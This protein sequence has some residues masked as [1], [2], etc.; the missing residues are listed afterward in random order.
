MADGGAVGVGRLAGRGLCLIVAR[1]PRLPL[2]GRT[3]LVTGAGSGIGAATSR[4]LAAAGAGVAL[5]DLVAPDDLAAGLGPRALALAADVTDRDAISAAVDATV[6]RFGSLD[7]CFANAGIAA[8]TPTT[9]AGTTEEE[10]ERIIDVDV[11][12]VWR[13]VRAALPAITESRGH[14]LVTSSMYAYVNGA[15]NAPYGMAKAAVESL[16]R[17]LRSE[18]A[19]TGVTAGVLYPGWVRTPIIAPSHVEHPVAKE[20]IRMAFP[21]PY[22]SPIAPERIAAAIVAGIEARRPR[23]ICPRRWIPV[24]MARGV[25]NIASDALVDRDRRMQDLMRRIDDPIDEGAAP[26]R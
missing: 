21:G 20:L 5:V 15:A 7:V 22:G 2:P 11:H 23:I 16:G 17:S 10:Y 12:G 4:A 8:A 6:D 1:S 26:P 24:S 18:M 13:T 25:V 14:V 3:V 9:I 19:G